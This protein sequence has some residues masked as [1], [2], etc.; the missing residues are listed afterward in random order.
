MIRNHADDKAI[1]K[2]RPYLLKRFYVSSRSHPEKAWGLKME[3]CYDF[4]NCNKT[5]CAMYK[6]EGTMSCW[7]LEEILFAS[8]TEG[9]KKEKKYKCEDCLYYES[10]MLRETQKHQ[11]LNL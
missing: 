7:E 1:P 4:M 6:R 11:Y 2:I 5:S 10:M 9:L 3:A 8:P